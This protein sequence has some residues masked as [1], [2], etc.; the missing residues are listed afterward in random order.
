MDGYIQFN[1]TAPWLLAA[2]TTGITMY[3][4]ETM[5]VYLDKFD[6]QPLFLW[7]SY[8]PQRSA[9]DILGYDLWIDEEWK[10]TR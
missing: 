9:T 5:R 2:C 8:G 7:S 1:T 3:S 6:Y 4:T 10:Y